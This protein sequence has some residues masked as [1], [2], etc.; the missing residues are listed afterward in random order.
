MGAFPSFSLLWFGAAVMG[1]V[2]GVFVG[3]KVYK[4]LNGELM[5]KYVYGFMA[6]S[7]LWIFISG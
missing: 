6:L 5:K 4:Y 1:L 2:A 7:G 3:S